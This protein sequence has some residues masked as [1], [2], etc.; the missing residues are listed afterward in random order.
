[1]NC[2]IQTRGGSWREDLET[3]ARLHTDDPGSKQTGGRYE[4]NKNEKSWD[5][6]LLNHLLYNKRRTGVTRDQI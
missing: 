5:P 4:V 2:R 3:L 6:T 1:M